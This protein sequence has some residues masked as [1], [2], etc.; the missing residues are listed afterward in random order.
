[1]LALVNAN[2]HIN[3]FSLGFILYAQGGLSSNL[4]LL[5]NPALEE[6][7]N[8]ASF[9]DILPAWFIFSPG[10]E[11]MVSWRRVKIPCL[12]DIQKFW[13]KARFVTNQ[14]DSDIKICYI[15]SSRQGL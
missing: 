9:F 3:Q 15:D 4:T 12:V 13:I 10:Q 7:A 11:D 1:L 2:K 14:L 8:V 5:V 6:V